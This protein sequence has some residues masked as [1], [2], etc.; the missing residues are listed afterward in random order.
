MDPTAIQDFAVRAGATLGKITK[1]QKYVELTLSGLKSSNSKPLEIS[2]PRIQQYFEAYQQN[3]INQQRWS[4]GVLIFSPISEVN[5]ASMMGN[6]FCLLL[7]SG[8]HVLFSLA[9]GFA[10][11]GGI[12][13]GWASE[14]K[15]CEL[16]GPA[17]VAAYEL[18]SEI[19]QYPRI[20]VGQ[21]LM[22]YINGLFSVANP[23]L[24]QSCNKATAKTAL[25]LIKCDVDG[26]YIIDYL[27][28]GFSNL[29]S[30]TIYN[31]AV[32]K[33]LE[34]VRSQ[35]EVFQKERNT[36][37]AFRDHLLLSYFLANTNQQT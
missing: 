32:S 3:S 30:S 20:V 11:R 27:G 33:A 25:S 35:L 21:Q 18:E 17:V 31:E 37:L 26:V 36:K 14:L 4:D 24:E 6:V 23:D 29:A 1:L 9:E 7:S 13:I 15:P 16:Y 12:E 8:F 5:K 28:P 19:A 10:I 22:Q 2:D 34:F